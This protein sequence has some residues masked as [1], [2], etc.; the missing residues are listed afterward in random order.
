MENLSNERVSEPIRLP[1]LDY[2]LCKDTYAS[3]HRWVQ[4]VGKIKMACSPWTNHSWHTTLRVT[5]TGLTT[6]PFDANGKSASIDLDFSDHTI[7]FSDSSGIKISEALRSEPVKDFYAKV[8]KIMEFMDIDAK[9]DLFPSE[10]PES[11]A[12]DKDGVNRTYNPFHAADFWQALSAIDLIFQSFR[13]GF[14]GK[15]SPVHFFWG[16]FDLALTRFSGREAPEHPAGI[17][18]LPDL[19]AKEAY[20]HEVVS[21]GFFPGNEMYPRAAFYSYAYPEPAGFSSIPNLLE[22][23][24][25]H[26]E[27]GEYLLPYED[28]RKSLNPK[29]M[30]LKFF[31][32]TY[33]AAVNFGGWEREKLEPG[34]Y[35]KRL[36]TERNRQAFH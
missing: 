9:F 34:K 28:V 1:E 20:S 35:L 24:F 29:T 22:S 16:S 36:Q 32:A 25:Y 2:R 33:E 8:K 21:F 13:A 15:S 23:A 14:S 6:L 7:K 19:V 4:I 5:P 3:L 12:F 31:N 26:T 10:I 30:I 18:N 17:P 11:L 27:M